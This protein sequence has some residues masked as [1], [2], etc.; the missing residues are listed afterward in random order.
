MT[1]IH[2]CGAD[3]DIHPVLAK[4]WPY[5]LPPD[6]WPSFCG[7]GKF[8]DWLITDSPCGVSASCVCADHDATW[9]TSEN[10]KFAAI[11]GNFKLYKNLRAFLL[12]NS[13]KPRWWIESTCL[14][15][16]RGVCFGA[17]I[18][19]NP[20]GGGD[21]GNKETEQIV[22]RIQDAQQKYILK[23]RNTIA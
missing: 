9:S 3:L 23:M 10:T 19:F 6:Q 5:D 1:M 12:V 11:A 14:W 2:Y 8:G 21:E 18:H 7:A 20:I 22:K 4:V 13:T 15:W 17:M 16:F